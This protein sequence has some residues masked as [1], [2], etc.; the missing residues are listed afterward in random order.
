MREILDDLIKVDFYVIRLGVGDIDLV[1]K[2]KELSEK[3]QNDVR[4]EVF[5]CV[6]T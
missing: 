1:M 6:F 4:P 3:L 2:I 5:V